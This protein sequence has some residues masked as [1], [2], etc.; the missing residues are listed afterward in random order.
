MTL[1]LEKWELRYCINGN[2]YGVAFK[3][4]QKQSIKHV[5]VVI[6]MVV[7]M[8]YCHIK[9]CYKML[10]MFAYFCKNVFNCD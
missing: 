1:D 2:D 4:S 6:T 9:D 10:Y 5:L 7:N 8:N 3:I